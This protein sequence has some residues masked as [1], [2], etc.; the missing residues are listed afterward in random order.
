MTPTGP[1][2]SAPEPGPSTL[3]E[4]GSRRYIRPKPSAGKFF[5]RRQLV[6]YGL[7]LVFFLIPYLR[8]GG[9]PLILLDLPHRLFILF[10]TT[11][12]PTDTLLFMLLFVSVAI[13]IFL[14][15]ALLGR[16]WCGWACPQ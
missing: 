16:V 8:M 4:D 2:A 11:F 9:K 14:L 3:N 1:P 15:T 13:A 6:A 7:M 10:G 12:L 5:T